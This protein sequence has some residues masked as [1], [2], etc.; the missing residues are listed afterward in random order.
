ME[1]CQTYPFMHSSSFSLILAPRWCIRHV[2]VVSCAGCTLT[3]FFV[4][5]L[6]FLLCCKIP[7]LQLLPPP[8]SPHLPPY[9]SF[10]SPAQDLPPPSFNYSPLHYPTTL[11]VWSGSGVTTVFVWHSAILPWLSVNIHWGGKGVYV[12]PLKEFLV[13]SIDKEPIPII[14][15]CTLYCCVDS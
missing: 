1:Y 11:F 2:G 10:L 7:P 13:M 9:P 14:I 4:P 3:L 6:T 15:K 5:M 8:T 12:P